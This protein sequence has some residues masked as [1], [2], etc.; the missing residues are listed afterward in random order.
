MPSPIARRYWLATVL[1]VALIAFSYYALRPV[2]EA[3]ALTSGAYGSTYSPNSAQ[4]SGGGGR[5]GEERTR[6]MTWLEG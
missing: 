1:V 4:A 3:C 6:F 2:R 5:C